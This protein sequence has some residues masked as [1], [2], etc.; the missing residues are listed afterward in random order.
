MAMAKAQEEKE[1]HAAARK[2][3]KKRDEKEV[4]E[5]REHDTWARLY[6]TE[7]CR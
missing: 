1:G 6:K 5:K 2:T 4:E 7:D 3:R